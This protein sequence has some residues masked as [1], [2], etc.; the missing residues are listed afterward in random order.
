MNLGWCG[1]LS[2]WRPSTV[3]T[4]IVGLQRYFNESIGE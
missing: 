1:G 3:G 2:S 4:D